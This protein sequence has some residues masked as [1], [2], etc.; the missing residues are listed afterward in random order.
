VGA[1]RKFLVGN[2][3]SLGF[4]LVL[5]SRDLLFGAAGGCITGELHPAGVF[6]GCVGQF[7]GADLSGA[8][9]KRTR[10]VF[11]KSRLRCSFGGGGAI[12]STRRPRRVL[13]QPVRFSTMEMW[14]G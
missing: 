7:H 5:I 8:K 6:G 11:G 1:L 13:E 4:F 2:I 9:V 10:R 3:L 12:P 14:R